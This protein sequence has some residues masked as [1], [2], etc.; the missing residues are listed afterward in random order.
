MPQYQFHRLHGTDLE[1]AAQDGR[2][3]FVSG[4]QASE[5]E[6]TPQPAPQAPVARAS[7]RPASDDTVVLYGVRLEPTIGR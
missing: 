6:P 3:P 7:E 2:T 1:L 5:I 4:Q